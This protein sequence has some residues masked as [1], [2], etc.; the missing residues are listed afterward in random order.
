MTRDFNRVADEYES[1]VKAE[2]A[3]LVESGQAAPL[4][5][6]ERAHRIV[7][8]RRRD[9]SLRHAI[10]DLRPRAEELK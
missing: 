8:R 4:D 9:R 1:E 10:S 2:A 7:Q 6:I 5:A 3:R